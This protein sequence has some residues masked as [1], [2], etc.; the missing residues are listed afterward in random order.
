MNTVTRFDCGAATAWTRSLVTTIAAAA[1][2][3]AAVALRAA[4][5]SSTQS[6]QEPA[7]TRYLVLDSRIIEKVAGGKLTLGAV[8]KDPHN[9]LFRGDKPWE[10]NISNGYPNVLFDEDEQLYKCWY[11][12]WIVCKATEQI[13]VEKRKYVPHFA[14]ER[15]ASAD[16]SDRIPYIPNAVYSQPNPARE[17][18]VCYATSRDGIHWEKPDL[19][20]AELN[21]SRKNNLVLS[22]QSVPHMAATQESTPS[23]N[24]GPHGAGVFKDTR[25]TDPAK[26]YKMVFRD[27]LAAEPENFFVST[28]FSPDGVNWKTVSCPETAANG[29]AHNNAF[30]SPEIQKYVLITRLWDNGRCVGR[31][32]S[33]DFV[34][35]TKAEVVMRG[36]YSMPVFRFAGLYIGLPAIYAGGGGRVYTELAWSPDTIH[37]SRVC[38]GKPLLANSKEMGVYDW[39]C[40][41]AS[42]P[43]IRKDGIQLFYMGDPYTHHSWRNS[44][45]CLASLRPDGFAGYE[46]VAEE[47]PAIITTKPLACAGRAL[48]ISADVRS[49]GSIR[50]VLSDA[51]GKTLAES[52]VVSSRPKKWE[53]RHETRTQ[54]ADEAIEWANDWDFS[55]M[56]G[57]MV[58]LTF[59]LEKAKLYSFSFE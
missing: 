52:N 2:L 50:V 34:H 6:A 20:V 59:R 45:L 40:I 31:C 48:R 25:E 17:S 43:V 44:G 54:Y 21:G 39:G 23:K 3:T 51:E 4:E 53:W 38:P 18:G 58:R 42:P 12:P 14:G 26:R 57:K 47:T 27:Y 24:R 56:D 35:W 15:P 28:A 13:P 22:A 11:S 19:G 55:A 5:T 30:W 33:A 16:D 49:G 37:W 41:Y 9:P 1:T 10:P 46:P 7:R 32:E 29:D 8:K 36:P